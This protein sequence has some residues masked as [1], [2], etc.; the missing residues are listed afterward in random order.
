MR[1]LTQGSINGLPPIHPR[2]VTDCPPTTGQRPVGNDTGGA[3]RKPNTWGDRLLQR[4]H[5]RV[6]VEPVVQTRRLVDDIKD[7]GVDGELYTARCTRGNLKTV[8]LRGGTTKRP[9]GSRYLSH[10]FS[11]DGG[12]T[13]PMR[14]MAP[15]RRNTGAGEP[16]NTLVTGPI[17]D[18]VLPNV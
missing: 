4:R 7:T 16:E 1:T 10:P 18:S 14:V 12:E 17:P 2:V 13:L 11:H 5:H 6:R 15:A 9:N 8:V 3:A